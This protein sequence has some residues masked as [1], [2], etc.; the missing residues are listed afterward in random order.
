MHVFSNDGKFFAHFNTNSSWGDIDLWYKK[1]KIRSIPVKTKEG[2]VFSM[3]FSPDNQFILASPD[4]ETIR[5]WHVKTGEEVN[6][7]DLPESAFNLTYSPDGRMLAFTVEKTLRIWDSET[8]RELFVF[9]EEDDGIYSIAFSP[10]SKHIVSVS[11]SGSV[12]VWPI[13]PLQDIIDETRK[14]FKD[15]P[16]TPEE[17]KKYYLE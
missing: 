8:F 6:H 16:L 7:F 3:T 12:C 15:R 5:I 10:D 13:K 1:S 11:S 9:E 14:R 2:Y 17:R 4:D